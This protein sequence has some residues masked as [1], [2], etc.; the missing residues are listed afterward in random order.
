MSGSS[1]DGVDLAYC[2][3]IH[4]PHKWSY[5]I[6]RAETIPYP[7]PLLQRLSLPREYDQES[8][9][10]VDAELGRFY[11]GL[12]VSFH[13]RHRLH[14]ELVAS[15]GHTL[16]HEPEKGITVQAGSGEI[17]ARNT[18]LTVVSDFRKADVAQGGQG[19]PLV[20]VGDRLLF[21]NY[22]GCLN[23]GG[24]ANI[25]Y[26]DEKGRRIA[27]DI[28]PVNMALNWLAGKKGKEFDKGGDMARRGTVNPG[29]LD[30]LNRLDYYRNP[31]PKS[32]GREWFTVH[33]LPLLKNSTLETDDLMATATE[34]ICIQIS[35]SLAGSGITSVLVTG[36]G[37]LN[38]FLIEKLHQYTK[39]PLEIPGSLLVRYKEALIF[40]LLGVLRLRDEIN[41]LASVTGGR[42]D[43]SSGEIHQ[44]E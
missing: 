41:V 28:C 44:P 15:H 6:I 21:G 31:P 4:L 5:R 40:A 10:K 16:L 14:P 20:P 23:L 9:R 17:M 32:L 25:S 11:A 37:A 42:N 34:H 36:G 2:H 43:L 33:F 12:I 7:D 8:I 29:L 27:F 1:L 26:D 19:A 30:S 39:I 24:I 3:F 13:N 18:G 22:G 38:E 35:A